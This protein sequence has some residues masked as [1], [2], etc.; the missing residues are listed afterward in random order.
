MVPDGIGASVTVQND[1]LTGISLAGAWSPGIPLGDGAELSG[2]GGQVSFSPFSFGGQATIGF[3]PEFRGVRL[4][5]GTLGFSA[6]FNQDQTITGNPGIPDG[7]TLHDVPLTITV[8]GQ[9][10]LL[11]FITLGQGSASFYDLPGSALI[12]ANVGLPS[13]LTVRC[14][15]F[16]GGGQF[17]IEPSVSVAGDAYIDY[18][19]LANS[20]FNLIGDGKLATDLCGLGSFKGGGDAVISNVGFAVCFAID[21][22]A[23]GLGGHWPTT[24]PSSVAALLDDFHLYLEGGCGLGPYTAEIKLPQIA[25]M[26]AAGSRA[27]GLGSFRLPGGPPF[28]V[29]K[30]TGQGRPPL[31]ALDGPRG[32][33]VMM[34]GLEQLTVA[35]DRY[36]VTPDPIDHTTYIELT[37]PP[38]GSYRLLEQPGSA[39][40]IAVAVAHGQPAPIVRARVAARGSLRVLAWHASNLDGRRLVFRELGGAG[41]RLLLSTTRARGRLRFPVRPGLVAKRFV[42]VQVIANGIPVRTQRIASY[43]GPV[44]SPPGRPSALHAHRRRMTLRASWRDRGASRYLVVVQLPGHIRRLYLTRVTRL[45]LNNVPPRGR[46]TLTVTAANALGQRGR[47]ASITLR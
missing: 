16:L 4:F 7:Y 32:L 46:V 3:G 21:G 41:D 37:R 11:S 12:T 31:L 22:N 24:L 8:N 33:R 15:S 9:L 18:S 17:G 28:A 30:V 39:P 19:D 25:R 6:A 27:R 38:G 2:P 14:P 43:R 42:E 26:A 34:V 44:L 35:R 36:L 45:K 20:D 5:A 40:V 13:S 47:S 23:D 10:Q 1:R 29:V